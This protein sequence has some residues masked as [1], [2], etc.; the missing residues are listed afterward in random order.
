MAFS[1][2][3]LNGVTQMDL[4]Q[5]TTD[6]SKT[7]QSY[8]GHGADGEAF[9]GTY[10]PSGATLQTKT[11][12]Y[13]PT[14][15]A[16]S[17]TIT[18]DS[19]YDGLD[20]VNVT[21]S[22]VQTEE[23]SLSDFASSHT[24]F[25][26]SGKYYSRVDTSAISTQTKTVSPDESTKEVTPD[27]GK[28]LSQVTVNAISSTYVG[29]GVARKSSTDLTASGATV[30]APAGYYTYAAEKTIASGTAGTPTATKGAVNNHSVTITPSVTNTTGYITGGTKTG[31]GVTV[32]ASEL[33]S[34]TYNITTSG[35]HNVTNYASATVTF[36]TIYSGSSN[37]SSSTGANGDI[38][39]KVVS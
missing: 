8:T 2:I 4:T 3:I 20:E 33:V 15:S 13:T 26:S 12:S 36:S 37:P 35:T 31:T 22:A 7:L 10:A 34:G 28:Y 32:S 1:K 17:E 21:V 16:Q 39:I 18:A 23:L 6:A 24:Y 25:P 27:S 9:V 30:T 11:V 14:G 38:Y 19:G 29:S 5:D